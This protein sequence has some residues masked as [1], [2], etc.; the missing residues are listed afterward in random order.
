MLPALLF[1]GYFYLVPV[2]AFLFQGVMRD[3][4][5]TVLVRTFQ[6]LS[7]EP[8][9][10]V[11]D[12]A[13]FRALFTDLRSADRLYIGTLARELGEEQEGFR[14]AVIRASSAARRESGDPPSYRAWFAAADPLWLEPM[15]WTGLRTVRSRLTTR[16]V[17]VSSPWSSLGAHGPLEEH[18]FD[19]SAIFIRT[20]G[21]GL[22]VG[23]ACLLL[24]APVAYLLHTASSRWLVV[25]VAIVLISF[26][27]SILVRTLSWIVFFQK[28]GVVSA[29]LRALRLVDEPTGLLGT[30]T[31]T[32]VGMIHVLL[33]YMIFPLYDGMRKIPA[34]QMRA[35]LSLGATPVKA[36]LLVYIPQLQPAIRAGMIIVF[37][38][39][40][41]FYLT[42]LL[43][44][45]SGNQLLSFYT[46]F[47]AQKIG[48]WHVAAALSLWLLVLVAAGGL[49][50][51]LLS[52][53]QTRWRGR[54]VR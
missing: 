41:G 20:I 5:S 52:D 51:W 45:G 2:V 42:P 26:W 54:A 14:S 18:T 19:F 39:T 25:L 33:P 36:I 46:A 47:F 31:A 22:A 27:T 44:G 48:N 28:E 43:L 35:A 53:F 23:F 50:A 29:F 11:P 15:V 1:V 32:M 10:T 24:A 38:L 17:V 7:A 8:S 30:W 13:V 12:E 16:Y 21:A 49:T 6:S 3:D 9:A 4:V 40:I 37:T 34:E